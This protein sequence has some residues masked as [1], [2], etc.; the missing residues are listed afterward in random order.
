MVRTRT[1]S[2][3]PPG[4][5]RVARDST[6]P[7]DATAYW[8]HAA[9]HNRA[10]SRYYPWLRTTLPELLA[11]VETARRIPEH[12]FFAVVDKT[13]PDLTGLGGSPE[14]VIAGLRS[15]SSA[16]CSSARLVGRGGPPAVLPGTPERTPALRRV[17]RCAH[18]G[19]AASNE[20]T[21]D[22]DMAP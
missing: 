16:R 22:R 2:T 5:P 3:A 1:T 21:A 18:P 19:T 4:A 7:A 9:P 13:R 6:R 17:Q 10:L 14:G 11:H 12:V 8:A 20:S 15:C